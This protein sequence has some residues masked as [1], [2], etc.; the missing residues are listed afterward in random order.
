MA[1][2]PHDAFSCIQPDEVA[3]C[4]DGVCSFG[5]LYEQL[6]DCVAKYDNS[7]RENIEDVGPGDVVGINCVTKFWAG[8]QP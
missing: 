8:P 4:W 1:I 5:N 2:E 3:E 6:W 7:W